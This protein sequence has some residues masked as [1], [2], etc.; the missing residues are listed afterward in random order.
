MKKAFITGVTGQDGSYLSELLSDKGYEVYGLT[1]MSS[2]NNT[3]RLNQCIN[4]KN[5]H[6]V[7]GDMTDESSL[8]QAVSD[9]M[10]DE[11]YN[12]AAQSHVGLSPKFSEYTANINAFGLLRLVNVIKS[13]KIEKQV[14]IYQASTSEIF[15]NS[16]EKIFNEKSKLNPITPY[17]CSKSYA[18]LLAKCL[19]N[20]GIYIVNG[21][22]FPHE[23]PRRPDIFVTRKI[24]KGACKIKLGLQ[25]K[26]TLGNIYVQKDFGHSKDYVKA[27]H[28]S[29]QQKKPDDYIFSTGI[30]TSIKDFIIKVFNELDIDIRFKGVGLNEKGFDAKTNKI[31]LEISSE[32]YRKAENI[33]SKGDNTKAKEILGWNPEIT[34]DELIK[35]MVQEDLKQGKSY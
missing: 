12:L 22:A 6:L 7:Y 10:P 11:I 14:K 5:F 32:F 34:V 30:S 33:M 26:L 4:K 24:T 9:I 35:E 13:L 28:L 19:R 23:S 25:D 16:E 27:M 3:S 1:R 20:E 17:A 21:I 2:V 18:Y 29:L 31:I 15:G 8:Y